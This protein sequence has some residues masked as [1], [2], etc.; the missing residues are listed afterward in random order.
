MARIRKSKHFVWIDALNG[1]PAP[2]D[3]VRRGVT[4]I[5]QFFLRTHEPARWAETGILRLSG[6]VARPCAWS[7]ADLTALPALTVPAVLVC[8]GNRRQEMH[9][10]RPIAPNELLWSSGAIGNAEWTG[11]PLSLLLETAGVQSEAA[12]VAFAGADGFGG[13]IPI[14]KALMPE[15]LVVYGMNNRP[16][17]VEHGGPLRL[18][19]PGYIGARSVKWLTEISVQR[20]PSEND[21]QRRAYR[22]YPAAYDSE[23]AIEAHRDEGMMLGSLPVNAAIV[24]PASGAHLDGRDVLIRGWAHGHAGHEIADVTVIVDDTHEMPAHLSPPQGQWAWRLWWRRLALP[25]GRHTIQARARDTSGAVQPEFDAEQWNYRGYLH[26]AQPRI[27]I[28]VA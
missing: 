11:V 10:L 6:Q 12:H 21:Y 8:A 9:A 22:L 13:S 20:E 18:V 7:L 16:L 4:P 26:H 5:N 24:L 2:V 19:V 1:S 14:E 27:T 3:L 25:P 17:P 15:V 28:T 23:A